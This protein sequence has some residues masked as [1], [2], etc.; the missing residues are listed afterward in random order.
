VTPSPV[1]I[2]DVLLE[3]RAVLAHL[4]VRPVAGAVRV[5]D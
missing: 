2:V 1:E 5:L 3:D 4:E